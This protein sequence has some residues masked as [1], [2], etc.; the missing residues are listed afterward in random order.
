MRAAYKGGPRRGQIDYHNILVTDD[1]NIYTLIKAYLPLPK[2][3]KKVL[4]R[5][6]K[7]PKL[8]SSCEGRNFL[9]FY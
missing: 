4:T 9:S 2:F 1:L 3:L 8:I 7:Y 5:E 6:I